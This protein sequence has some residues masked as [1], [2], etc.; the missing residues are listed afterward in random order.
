MSVGILYDGLMALAIGLYSGP[1]RGW[2]ELTEDIVNSYK[3]SR[4][5]LL[6]RLKHIF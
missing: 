3:K 2:D 6:N 1:E 4:D 5:K